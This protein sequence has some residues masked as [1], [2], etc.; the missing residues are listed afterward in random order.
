M[1]DGGFTMV[2]E[3]ADQSMSKKKKASDGLVTTMH[4]IS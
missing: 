2:K 3:G 1:T 4:G